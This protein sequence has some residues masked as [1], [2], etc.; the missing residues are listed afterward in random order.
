MAD[1]GGRLS[2]SLLSLRY[3]INQPW[4]FTGDTRFVRFYVGD[5]FAAPFFQAIL[6]LALITW[7]LCT[8]CV[9]PVTPLFITAPDLGL[10]RLLVLSKT[11]RWP[12]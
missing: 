9:V 8:R 12:A 7:W 3:V 4:L 1:T 10:S 11:S 6:M 5:F 2:T